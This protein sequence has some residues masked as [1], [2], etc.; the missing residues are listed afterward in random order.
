MDH[1]PPNSMIFWVHS[2]FAILITL[3]FYYEMYLTWRIY[4]SL[5][6]NYFKSQGFLSSPHVR[7]LILTEVRSQSEDAIRK[8]IEPSVAKHIHIGRDFND[9]YNLYK[10]HRDITFKM[11]ANIATFLKDPDCIKRPT[12]KKYLIF[13]SVDSISHHGKNLNEITRKIYQIRS[14][15]IDTVKTNSS[16]FAIFPSIV[17]TYSAMKH[18]KTP[19]INLNFRAVAKAHHCP[20]YDDL[21]WENIGVKP[22]SR[23]IKSILSAI[24]FSI[25]VFIWTFVTSF[26]L[27]LDNLDAWRVVPGIGEFIATDWLA[28][29]AVQSLISPLFTIIL[30][31]ILP[32]CLLY[33]A[34]LNG[35]I[36]QSGAERSALVTFFYFMIFQFWG[37]FLN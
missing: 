5:R 35:R 8:F 24:M 31:E 6:Q 32:L 3:Y 14:E 19:F 13:G 21:I 17:K 34:K 25:L 23:R 22:Y 33:I 20:D 27:G 12:H 29:I 16:A 37:I 4:I 10:E 26:G 36:S 18:L 30:N 11:E 2:L 15:P 28:G 9:L 1:I 7:I